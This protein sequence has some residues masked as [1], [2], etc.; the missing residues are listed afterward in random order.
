MFRLSNVTNNQD[1]MMIALHKYAA[2][3]RR[4]GAALQELVSADLDDTFRAVVMLA[5]F[6]VRP[7]SIRIFDS[8]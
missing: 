3:R 8:S 5:L 6:E 7:W 2:T 4:V 1:L